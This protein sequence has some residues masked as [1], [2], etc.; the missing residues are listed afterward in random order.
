M[1]STIL[2]ITIISIL[3]AVAITAHA[4]SA[5]QVWACK[6]KDGKTPQDAGTVSSAWL[7][8]AKGVKGGEKMKVFLDFPVA[9]NVG[10]GNFN[11]VLVTPS[12]D[13]WGAFNGAYDGSAAAKADEAFSDVA[14]CTSSYLWTSVEVE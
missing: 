5:V 7:K 6:L 4:E 2:K 3:M 10:G 8:A 14:T 12:F 13:E 11:F 1:K 9:A